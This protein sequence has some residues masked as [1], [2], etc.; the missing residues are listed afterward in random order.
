MT[1][2]HNNGVTQNATGSVIRANTDAN[3]AETQGLSVNATLS[4]DGTKVVFQSDAA[5]LVDG[6]NNALADIFVKDLTWGTVTRINTSV[7]GAE[8]NAGGNP[9]DPPVTGSP[10]TPILSADGSK[11]AFVSAAT[12]LVNGDTND[13]ADVFVKDLN[14]GVITRATNAEGNDE[15]YYASLSA[16][17]SKVAFY[18]Y[19]DNLVFGDNNGTWDVF[20][21]DMNTGALERVST[22][23]NG[24]EADEASFNPTLSA[25]GSKVAFYSYASNL[26]ENDTNGLVDVFVKDLNTG[27]ITRVNTDVNGV[28]ADSH[29]FDPVL[30]A[31]GTKVAFYSDASNLV[32][33]DTDTNGVKDVFVKDLQTGIVTRVSTDAEGTQADGE[34]LDVSLS[35][36][37]TKVLFSS[38]AT[39]L[40]EGDTNGVKDVFVKDLIT[41]AIVRVNTDV[42]GQQADGHEASSA[43]LS[44]DGTKVIFS[45]TASNLVDGD[46]NGTGDVFVK[47]I[48]YAFERMPN[49]PPV[50]VA[51][52]AQATIEQTLHHYINWEFPQTDQIGRAHV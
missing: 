11:V 44:A 31:D 12:N 45:S 24:S 47:D 22:T 52:T 35:A 40:V 16:D 29:G 41:G 10:I 14:T 21:K 23:S 36:D 48:S 26:V 4:A 13:W 42:N 2:S 6:D 30:S 7:T 15:S 37:G 17:G 50:T 9:I 1:T 18:S 38:E 5:N 27:E 8:A 28:E 32:V 51:D 49:S 33:G 46:N 43:M 39:N 3:G 25:D 20:V 34:S 19:A